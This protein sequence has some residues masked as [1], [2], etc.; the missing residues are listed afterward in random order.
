M[1]LSDFL[2]RQ[3]HNDSNPHQIIPIS[4]NM[5]SILQ[6]K[7]YNIRYNGGN[8]EKYLVQ[9]WSQAKSSE[10]KLPD[11]HG[12]SKSLDLNIQPEK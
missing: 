12:I 8:S 3:K 1:I 11:I 4:F 5:Y 6:D 2:T 10:I 7:Y 9:T